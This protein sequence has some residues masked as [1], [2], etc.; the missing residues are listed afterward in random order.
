M[1]YDLIVAGGGISGCAAAT[2]AVPKGANRPKRR[3]REK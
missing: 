2:T 1:E 3:V